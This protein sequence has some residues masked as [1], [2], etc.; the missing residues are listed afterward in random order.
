[1]ASK[2]LPDPAVPKSS[3]HL[4]QIAVGSIV[5][6]GSGFRASGHTPNPVF[7][8]G[9]ITGTLTGPQTGMSAT[10]SWTIRLPDGADS[11]NYTHFIR[12]V[13]MPYAVQL[14]L[15]V[16]P[17]GQT[18]CP[19]MSQTGSRFELWTVR[20]SP[21]TSYL[22]DVTFVSSQLP[23]A[24][25]TIRSEDPYPYLP[26]TRADR[27]FQVDLSVQGLV[28]EPQ[29][30]DSSK[31]V[32]LLKHV[33]P[34]Q[35]DGTFD[36]F[37]RF[38]ASLLS[39]STITTNGT[40]TLDVLMH[41]IPG[42]DRTRIR[43]EQRFSILTASDDLMAPAELASRF[44][45]IWPV[46]RTGISGITDG[47]TIGPMV[48]SLTFVFDDLY[49][50]STTFALIYKGEPRPGA[51]GRLVPGTLFLLNSATPQNRV[52]TVS[53]YLP[54]FDSD[55]LWTLEVL[56]ETPFGTDRMSAVT[57][58]VEGTVTIRENW[59]QLHFGSSSNSG[60]GADTNDFDHDGLSNLIEFAFGLNPKLRDRGTFPLPE[61]TGDSLRI[62]FNRPGGVG[63]IVY[64]AEWSPDMTPG[65][66]FPVSDS[67]VPPQH[68]FTI[69]LGAHPRGFMRIKVT[70]Q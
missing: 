3:S 49:P 6:L 44:I 48:P 32:T 2:S 51:T 19:L 33:Q 34:Y 45:Q 20:Q 21:L 63:G 39:E 40:F 41:S 12:Q 15:V 43:G 4:L 36:Q 69:P 10:M 50:S 57:F 5:I 59:R 16:E 13:V 31:S 68:D 22:L 60:D 46:A 53:D 14:D 62:R 35:A 52:A 54:L 47:Q 30:P 58:T 26:R 25:V 18:V 42:E 24:S 64:G 23:S 56:T 29:A 9:N 70:G 65:S 38:Q 66:W 27:P 61:N 1:M 55:G 8:V 67:G 17:S 37:D 11:A 28:Q 7:P